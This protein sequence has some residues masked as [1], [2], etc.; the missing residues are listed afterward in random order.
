MTPSENGKIAFNL[1]LTSHRDKGDWARACSYR[2]QAIKES[3]ERGKSLQAGCHPGCFRCRHRAGSC[4][5]L[6]SSLYQ[7]V[8]SCCFHYSQPPALIITSPAFNYQQALFIPQKKKASISIKNG[9][10]FYDLIS[11]NIW[12][13][14]L[15]TRHGHYEYK[16]DGRKLY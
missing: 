12:I 11:C 2:M 15:N 1:R 9:A 7:P 13:W 5:M 10:R 14:I 16:T 6:A 4:V 8:S 3:G